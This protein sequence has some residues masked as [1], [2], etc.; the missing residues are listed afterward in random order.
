MPDDAAVPGWSVERFRDY[1]RLLARLQLDER[2][3]GKLDPSDVV[4]EA[5]LKA[6]QG[7]AQCRGQTDAERAAWLRQVLANTLTDAA[8]RYLGADK[9]NVEMERSLQESSARLERLL[10]DAQSSPEEQTQRHEQLALLAEG[11][12]ALPDDQRQVVELRHLQGVAVGDIAR[13]MGRTR[14]AVAGLLRRGLD[15][16]RQRL[17]DQET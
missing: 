3:R 5:L 16:L 6:H 12:A 10:A 4:Q 8:R 13:R 9:R 17:T 7:Q 2:L 15:A 14:A 1:L 11:L